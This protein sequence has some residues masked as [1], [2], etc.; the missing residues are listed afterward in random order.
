[1]FDSFFYWYDLA[2]LYVW[3]GFKN[4]ILLS[5]WMLSF[6][7]FNL[8]TS[9]F[10][11]SGYDQTGGANCSTAWCNVERS[12]SNTSEKQKRSGKLSLTMFNSSDC[13]FS[14]FSCFSF[15]F[16]I[17]S[18]LWPCRLNNTKIIGP[19]KACCSYPEWF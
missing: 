13:L 1:M 15:I 14:Y 17:L 3:D 10:I 19:V 18:V 2:M 12:K 16:L 11:V 8:L 9:F 7:L 6:A 4:P 5:W